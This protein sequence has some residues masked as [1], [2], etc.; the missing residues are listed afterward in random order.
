MVGKNGVGR[1]VI[2]TIS[3]SCMLQGTGSENS[4][5]ED[6]GC[7]WTF[8]KS[9]MTLISAKVGEKYTHTWRTFASADRP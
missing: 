3:K 4:L 7:D 1:N 9:Y 6:V 2:G 8:S 5:P